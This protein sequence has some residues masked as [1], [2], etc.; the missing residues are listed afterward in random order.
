MKRARQVACRTW[1]AVDTYLTLSIA[2]RHRTSEVR[3][4]AITQYAACDHL[5]GAAESRATRCDAPKPSLA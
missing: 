4:A 3:D 2:D 5:R 1:A